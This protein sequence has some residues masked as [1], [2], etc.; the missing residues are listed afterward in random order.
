ML[1][2]L[3]TYRVTAEL[4]GFKKYEQAGISLG[5][6]QTAVIDVTLG[7]GDVNETVS[8]TADSPIVDPAKIDSGAT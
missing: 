3:G 8:V 4:E 2:P 1:L 6:G 5:A 7:V